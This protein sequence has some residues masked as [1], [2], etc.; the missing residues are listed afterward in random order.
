MPDDVEIGLKSG[1]LTYLTKPFDVP[2]LIAKVRNVLQK[3]ATY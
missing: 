3:P 2:D 1:F